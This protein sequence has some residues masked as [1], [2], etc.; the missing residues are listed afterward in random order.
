[1]KKFALLFAFVGFLALSGCEGGSGTRTGGQDSL[2]TDTVVSVPATSWEVNG[3]K[4]SLLS[5]SPE[6]P[7]AQLSL[8]NPAAGAKVP[9]GDF[10]FTFGVQNYE[11][12]P[13]TTDAETKGIANSGGGQHLHVILNNQPYMA[14]YEPEVK[15]KLETGHYTL[16]AFPS[17]SYHESVKSAGAGILRQFT[18]GEPKDAPVDVSGPTLV[19][20]RPKGT[21]VKA[22]GE[23]E[24]VLLDFYLLN[25][26]LSLE[27]NKIRATIDGREFLLTKWAPYIIE[28]LEIKDISIRLELV[29]AN[30]ILIP[31][32]FNRVERTIKLTQDN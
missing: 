16:V 20:S 13:Q 15:V 30:G 10:T 29:D 12:G 26:K 28:G 11:L 3:I 18:V 19:Y 8:D 32:P 23:T 5:D 21:Y 4:L 24:K 14:H 2:K 22:K 25:T 17:R 1:M 9:P 6:Y 27:G 7:G 31:G